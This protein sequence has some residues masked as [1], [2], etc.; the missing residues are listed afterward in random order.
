MFALL[1]SGTFGSMNHLRLFMFTSIP[2][3]WVVEDPT[4]LLP[5][6]M[7]SVDANAFDALSFA[8][9]HHP[10]SPSRET[11]VDRDL[12]LPICLLH[13][14]LLAAI[15]GDANNPT[16]A[17]DPQSAVRTQLT[18]IATTLFS[19]FSRMWELKYSST[20]KPPMPSWFVF[21]GLVYLPNRVDIVAHHRLGRGSAFCVVS[22][23]IE[24]FTIGS[25][26]HIGDLLD[27]AMC[28]MTLQRH[29]FRMTALW[30]DFAWPWPDFNDCYNSIYEFLGRW[31]PS[32][33]EA[34]DLEGIV[35]HVQTVDVL[36]AEDE[37]SWNVTPE[38]KADLHRSVAA[39]ATHVSTFNP[40][41]ATN[42][43]GD[44]P[45]EEDSSVATLEDPGPTS[46][47]DPAIPSSFL[48]LYALSSSA[49]APNPQLPIVREADQL[50]RKKFRDAERTWYSRR[51]KLPI[52]MPCELVRHPEAS[53][54][55]I[56]TSIYSAI[57]KFIRHRSTNLRPNVHLE[58]ASP[59]RPAPDFFQP[60]RSAEIQQS[61]LALFLSIPQMS[62][63]LSPGKGLTEGFLTSVF[64]LQE[65]SGLFSRV[66]KVHLWAP[67]PGFSPVLVLGDLNSRMWR[68]RVRCDPSLLDLPRS[69]IIHYVAI[70]ALS[71]SLKDMICSFYLRN[72]DLYPW[73]FKD[74][75][76]AANSKLVQLPEHYFLHSF[77]FN[78]YT[79]A[80]DLYW[81]SM[82]PI[83]D[84][85]QY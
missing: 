71:P 54:Q 23:T 52:Q 73:L 77:T 36:L 22:E 42:V 20:S 61:F 51:S 24:S 43:F 13:P 8:V 78:D 15:R 72:P 41:A 67:Q 84:G 66:F 35:L 2:G 68:E 26:E 82:G 57:I 1:H 25:E 11:T 69:T 39:W 53:A 70:D 37:S 46:S 7:D 60:L 85:K 29:V 3:T 14:P 62:M 5:E 75:D 63:F 18:S 19:I 40:D 80:L 83:I 6:W 65:V 10:V 16:S 50:I 74:G 44:V 12:R 9:V 30:E 21:F 58:S 33:S 32:P 47:H 45:C 48:D 31:T 27:L 17:S 79:C 49:L 28:L 59:P 64:G 81:P 76:I 34:A 4:V 38:E 56:W 55:A